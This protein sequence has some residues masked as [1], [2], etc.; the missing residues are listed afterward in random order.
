MALQGTLR[1][2]NRLMD[3][4]FTEAGRNG[5][6]EGLIIDVVLN[7]RSEALVPCLDIRFADAVSLACGQQQ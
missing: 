5:V 3:K 4:T 2:P 7:D 1:Q 6:T